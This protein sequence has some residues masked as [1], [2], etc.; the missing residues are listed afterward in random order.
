MTSQNA[1]T[2]DTT[3]PASVNAPMMSTTKADGTPHIDATPT[4]PMDMP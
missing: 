1:M 4:V 3:T 2:Q